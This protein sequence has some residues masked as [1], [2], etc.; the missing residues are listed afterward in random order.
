MRPLSIVWLGC[1]LFIGSGGEVRAHRDPEAPVPALRALKVEAELVVDGVLDEGFWQ[2]ADVATGL[3]DTRTQQPADQQTTLRVAYTRRF[4]YVAVECFDD[5]IQEIRATERREDRSFTGDDWVEL[6]L[7]P[8]HTHRSKYAFFTNPLGTRADA[9]EGPSG[10]FNYGWSAEWDLAARIE[11]N[12]WVFEMRIPFSI[13]NYERRDGQTWGLNLTRQL[14]RTD[15][16]SFWSFSVTDLYKPR[17]FGHLTHLDLADSEFDRNWEIT[18]YASVRTDFNGDTHTF[19]QAGL[20][21]GFRLTPSI[22]TALTLNPDF[23]QV[24]ADADTIELRDTERFLPERRPFFREGDELIRMP[25]RMYYSRRF[26]DIDGGLNTSGRWRGLGFSFLNVQGDV[27][28]NNGDQTYYGNSTVFRVL[29]DVGERSS[30]GYYGTGSALKQGHGTAGSLDGYFFLTDDWRI[31]LQTAVADESIKNP[32]HEPLKDRQDYLGFGSLIYDRYPWRFDL[33]Y[34]AITQEFDP[35]LGYIPRRDI[36]GPSFLSQLY[37]RS[38]GRHYKELSLT[39]DTQFFLDSQNETSIRDHN[40]SGRILTPSD[41]GLRLGQSVHYHAPY[42]NRRTR[43]GMSIF[44][45]DLWRSF[46]YGWAGGVFEET[47]YNE[48]TLAKPIK[49]WDRLPIRWEY[50]IRL[51][52]RPD[53]TETTVWLNRVVFDLFIAGNMWMKGSLQFQNDNVR[54]LSLICGWE[55]RP[56]TWWYL[57]FNNV[58]QPDPTHDSGNSIFTKVTYTF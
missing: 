9:S 35:L 38:D 34:T 23:G 10:M 33:G 44:T 7:D 5:R 19:F 14:R 2:Q 45:T 24:E 18:P 51:E 58:N 1:W 28:R 31:S 16:L 30:I 43:A 22:T 15:V 56:R 29:Q 41:I 20:D 52:D 12:R 4:L 53:G 55:I 49:F 6:H 26:T 54:N 50:V 3:V 27:S 47:D 32:E 21:V 11:T 37:L 39:Y 36:F 48:F 42:D 40:L 17:H 13:M 8:P 57:V 46:D 25:H